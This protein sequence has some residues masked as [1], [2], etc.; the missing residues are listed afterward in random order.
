MA[1]GLMILSQTTELAL[2]QFEPLRDRFNEEIDI[3]QIF[4]S[5]G[6]GDAVNRRLCLLLCHQATGDSR[7]YAE[8]SVFNRVP[9]A[10]KYLIVEVANDHL[11]AKLGERLADSTAHDAASHDPYQFY[12]VRRHLGRLLLAVASGHDAIMP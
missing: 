6:I 8:A 3:T 5:G 4:R 9:T 12:I 10:S 7:P 2:L 11:V 1:C